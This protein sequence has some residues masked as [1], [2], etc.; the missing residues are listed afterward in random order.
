MFLEI[1]ALALRSQSLTQRFEN[2]IKNRSLI[3]AQILKH[4]PSGVYRSTYAIARST[5]TIVILLARF[6]PTIVA[7][8]AF[9]TV[10]LESLTSSAQSTGISTVRAR[11]S[12]EW[13]MRWQCVHLDRFGHFDIKWSGRQL[14]QTC[15]FLTC[16]LRC[17]T[18][19]ERKSSH[20]AKLWDPEQLTQMEIDT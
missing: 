14:K 17:A 11:C 7:E 10:R 6:E 1:C 15:F 5:L 16:A 9:E 12:N 4:R 19:F 13:C 20:V 2:K 8:D 18:D 3:K